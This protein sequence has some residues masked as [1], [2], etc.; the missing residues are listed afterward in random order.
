VPELTPEE[1]LI[2]N[3]LDPTR[4]LAGLNDEEIN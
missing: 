3:I 2:E 1:Q 4:G